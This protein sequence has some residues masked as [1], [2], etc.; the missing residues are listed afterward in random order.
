MRK[1]SIII[2]IFNESENITF[3]VKEIFSCLKNYNSD[4]ELILVDDGS[5]DNSI[6]VINELKS[7][8]VSFWPKLTFEIFS[9]SMLRLL[10][11][12]LLVLY[13]LLIYKIM[14]STRTVQNICF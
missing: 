5:T 14:F 8:Y 6:L 7:T 3:L 13:T 1:F 9:R 10:S 2:P 12:I 11:E 4:F